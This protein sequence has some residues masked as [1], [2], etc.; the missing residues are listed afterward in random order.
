MENRKNWET[1]SIDIIEDFDNFYKHIL[2]VMIETISVK[3]NHTLLF[4]IAKLFV[5]FLADSS[6][7][8]LPASA[9]CLPLTICTLLRSV[10]L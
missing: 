6:F 1:C 4:A 9:V 8:F 5:I 2:N 10:K 3:H 7:P